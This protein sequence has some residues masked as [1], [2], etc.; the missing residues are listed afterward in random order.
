MKNP[1]WFLFWLIVLLFVSFIVA[2]LGAFFYIWTYLLAQCSSC[3]RVSYP[4]Q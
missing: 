3:F 1:L 4:A 2:L